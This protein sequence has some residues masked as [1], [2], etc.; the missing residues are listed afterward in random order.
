MR[1]AALQGGELWSPLDVSFECL[2]YRIVEDQL[3]YGIYEEAEVLN[4]SDSMLFDTVLRYPNKVLED[5]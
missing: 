1:E 2:L 4:H 3:F 5:H